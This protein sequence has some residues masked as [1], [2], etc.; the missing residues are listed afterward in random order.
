MLGRFVASIGQV[1]AWNK[2]EKRSVTPCPGLPD[3]RTDGW[4]PLAPSFDD[5]N[6]PLGLPERLDG[7]CHYC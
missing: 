7:C 3:S 1:P 4:V 6:T 2:A 5:G